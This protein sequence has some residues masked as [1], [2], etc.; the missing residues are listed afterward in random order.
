MVTIVVLHHER[1]KL[2]MP[3]TP[4]AIAWSVRKDFCQS[5]RR[6]KEQQRR[7]QCLA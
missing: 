5:I 6:T 2:F 7:L 1:M 4:H 3:F